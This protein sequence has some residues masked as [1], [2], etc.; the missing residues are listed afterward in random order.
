MCEALRKKGDHLCEV[1]GIKVEDV[2]YT[3]VEE[4]YIDSGLGLDSALD[5][6]DEVL[7]AFSFE[8]KPNDYDLMQASLARYLNARRF[9]NE[10]ELR[11]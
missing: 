7:A 8:E 3:F 1:H 10:L 2:F 4:N 11:Q 5:F 6:I 9:L